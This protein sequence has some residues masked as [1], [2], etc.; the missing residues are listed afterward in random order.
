MSAITTSR[1]LEGTL[2]CNLCCFHSSMLHRLKFIMTLWHYDKCFA[3]DLHRLLGNVPDVSWK[4]NSECMRSLLL[5]LTISHVLSKKRCH[6]R[7]TQNVN[8]YTTPTTTMF[9]MVA[10]M[11]I[12]SQMAS[13]DMDSGSSGG[14]WAAME[15]AWTLADEL[16]RE[17]SVL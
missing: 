13:R 15:A 7:Y 6:K 14:L 16:N 4:G 9:P 5:S 11:A 17:W 3:T 8:A 2:F 1:S 10:V 12:Q